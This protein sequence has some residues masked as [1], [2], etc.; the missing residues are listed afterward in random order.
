MEVYYEVDKYLKKTKDGRD[1]E[2]E[3]VYIKK[4]KK[5][6]HVRWKEFLVKSGRDNCNYRFEVSDDGRV[7]YW[8]DYWIDYRID[9]KDVKGVKS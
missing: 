4:E 7:R 9:G 8:I 3:E 2:W 5:V 6:P 1:L